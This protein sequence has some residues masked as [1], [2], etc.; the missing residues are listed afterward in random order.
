MPASF[1]F[2]TFCF[3]SFTTT[4]Y[5]THSP[6]HNIVIT[7]INFSAMHCI[8][9]LNI[10]VEIKSQ[11]KIFM[12]NKNQ[13]FLRRSGHMCSISMVEISSLSKNNFC[14]I[15]FVCYTKSFHSLCHKK[16]QISIGSVQNPKQVKPMGCS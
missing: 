9:L 10:S 4:K 13:T 5:L 8:V 14:E 11:Q 7:I 2:K 15:L 12:A 16:L 3:F 6:R 1:K